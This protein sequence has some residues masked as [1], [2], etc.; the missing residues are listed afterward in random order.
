[1]SSSA[2]SGDD[3]PSQSKAQ[4][5]SL[6]Q[7]F[8]EISQI[9][10]RIKEISQQTKMLSMR[11]KELKQETVN[12]PSLVQQLK[13]LREEKSQLSTQIADH[14]REISKFQQQDKH[15][16]D[17]HSQKSMEIHDSVKMLQEMK[18]NIQSEIE[19]I[20]RELRFTS[21]MDF[22]T[23]R[24]RLK[25][26]K[27]SHSQQ[28]ELAD[29]KQQSGLLNQYLDLK[30]QIL[31]LNTKIQA[32]E[33]SI[34]EPLDEELDL[35]LDD[36]RMTKINLLQAEVDECKVKRKLVDEEIHRLQ[37]QH[38]ETHDSQYRQL[39]AINKQLKPLRDEKDSLMSQ[40]AKLHSTMHT[41]HIPFQPHDYKAIVGK[42][43]HTIKKLQKE[44]TSGVKINVDRLKGI[45]TV[46]G[47]DQEDLNRIKE[48]IESLLQHDFE[49]VDL[50][51]QP[52]MYVNLIRRAPQLRRK[53]TCKI[54]VDQLEGRVRIKGKKENVQKAQK[55]VEQL[56]HSLEAQTISLSIQNNILVRFF[57]V[58]AQK[59][60][61]QKTGLS[62]VFVHEDRNEITLSGT[63]GNVQKARKEIDR[64]IKKAESEK[65]LQFSIPNTREYISRV[66]GKGGETIRMLEKLSKCKIRVDQNTGQVEIKGTEDKNLEVA[67]DFVTAVSEKRA[68][69]S[70]SVGDKKALSFFIGPGG[71][72]LNKLQRK[73]RCIFDTK[74]GTIHIQAPND[75][76]L[77]RAD[78]ATHAVLEEYNKEKETKSTKGKNSEGKALILSQ[79]DVL[80]KGDTMDEAIEQQSDHASATEDVAERVDEKAEKARPP[81]KRSGSFLSP[82]TY[83]KPQ[84]P[85]PCVNKQE[86]KEQRE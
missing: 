4:T 24:E 37:K 57:S 71:K 44:A 10:A 8:H 15:V 3:S 46:T 70:I 52:S 36:E 55:T 13:T 25:R 69:K 86:D 18:V 66:I 53:T 83:F 26:M 62:A 42:K 54:F 59:N 38:R 49:F 20:S 23:H 81:V 61:R 5:S 22:N 30:R 28:A 72:R 40:L 12:S 73:L 31:Q 80:N 56:L 45:C 27:A 35:I 14:R 84:P 51:F 9:N 64:I 16:H 76:T 58:R 21:V 47:S 6:T 2:A 74:K 7:N 43:G 19:K 41:I 11:Q 63:R 75:E 48:K 33:Q 67:R 82:K 50:R 79:D 1:M 65:E 39:D 32:M 17:L 60:L 29:L 34:L 85:L 77:K 78:E 68:F